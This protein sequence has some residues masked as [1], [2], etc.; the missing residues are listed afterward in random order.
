MATHGSMAGNKTKEKQKTANFATQR[1]LL[2]VKMQD[3]N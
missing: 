3:L 2:I 1:L